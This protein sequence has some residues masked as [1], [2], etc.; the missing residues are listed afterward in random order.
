MSGPTDG[1]ADE[2]I[3]VL[4]GMFAAAIASLWAGAFVSVG[5]WRREVLDASLDDAIAAGPRP[6]RD[7]GRPSA[8]WPRSE[9]EQLPPPFVY[10]IVTAMTLAVF[11]AVLFGGYVALTRTRVGSRRAPRLG[12]EPVARMARRSDL[13]SLRV[14]RPVAG[15]FVF[16]KVG[17]QLVTTEDRRLGSGR[18]FGRAGKAGGDRA[19]MAVFGPPRSGKTATVVAGVLDWAGP[20]ILSSVKAD[21][22]HETV[23]RRRQVGSVFVFDPFGEL[24]EAVDGVTRVSWSPLLSSGSISG[25]Q[26]AAQTLL[27]AGPTDGVTNA[28]YWSSKGK[29][30]LWPMLF[31]AAAG[32]RSM[33]DVVRWLSLQIGN[34]RDSSSDVFSP[35]GD[36][37]GEVGEILRAELCGDGDRA[38]EASAA[39]IAL[40]GFLQLDP[41]TR[42][43]IFSTA[44]TLIEAWEDPY[45]A[46]A[47]VVTNGS[48]NG[49]DTC[50]GIDLASVIAG[51]NTLYIVQP[52]KA[53]RSSA[54]VFGGLIGDLLR[55]QAYELSQRAGEPIPTTSA[56]IDEAGNTPLRWLPE[57]ASTC[58]SVGVQLVTVWQ[59][60]AQIRPLYK[61]HTDALLT[62]H[63]TKL[64]FSGINDEPTCAYA[65]MLGGEEEVTQVST[66]AD[67]HLAG[68]RRSVGA[69]TTRLRLIAPDLLRQM[70][71][72]TALL[73]HG[74]LPPAHLEGRRHWE[75]RRLR[76]LQAGNGPAPEPYVLSD[77]MAATLRMPRQIPSFVS[78]HLKAAHRATQAVRLMRVESTDSS[79]GG[80]VRRLSCP[81]PANAV[82]TPAPRARD[83]E[84]VDAAT[85]L[86]SLADWRRRD[87]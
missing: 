68:S 41:R 27:E 17:G 7:P 83:D 58:A 25:A 36:A 55:D 69:S 82:A 6:L 18:R 42:S 14:K 81:R 4:I 62:N 10:W 70:P 77:A 40:G 50:R 20:A 5:L 61:A 80:D 75:D 44:Q 31:A 9:A 37:L 47:S 15:R 21:L 33:A 32:Q 53:M 67:V 52:L 26:Q 13:A 76:R 60:L 84:A 73:F 86:T 35:D 28:N 51:A 72:N 12:V 8:A 71:A 54:V 24:P 45:I 23:A 29:A 85:D 38:G 11:C 49:P 57:V 56:V 66:N 87:P 48:V 22:F 65:S 3:G 74:R 63:G 19:C 16:G 2:V 34:D 59:S 64:F 78:S 39:L 79:A 1:S 43:D 46:A 30:L